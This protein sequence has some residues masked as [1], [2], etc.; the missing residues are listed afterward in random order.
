MGR[1]SSYPDGLNPLVVYLSAADIAAGPP[2]CRLSD[3]NGTT[4]IETDVR[5]GHRDGH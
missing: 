5:V 4:Y 1:I 3:V 2:P